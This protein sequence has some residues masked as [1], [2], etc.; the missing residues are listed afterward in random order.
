MICHI[1][2]HTY[3]LKPGMWVGLGDV[4]KMPGRNMN[5]RMDHWSFQVVQI[6]EV[7][8]T[9]FR[10]FGDE[11]EHNQGAPT[12]G[13]HWFP[14]IITHVYE[15]NPFNDPIDVPDLS[16]LLGGAL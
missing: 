13:W 6:R 10:I 5:G 9:S 8:E 14:D 15:D 3:D 12:P 7:R 11:D 1:N 2:G 4:S 16:L